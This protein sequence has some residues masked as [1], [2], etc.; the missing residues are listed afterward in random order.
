MVPPM[1][2]GYIASYKVCSPRRTSGDSAIVG[3]ATE[4]SGIAVSAVALEVE[5]SKVAGL[6][7]EV[8]AEADLVAVGSVVAVAR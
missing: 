2:R 8:L 6:I 1:P 7:V 5:V 4:T 3:R